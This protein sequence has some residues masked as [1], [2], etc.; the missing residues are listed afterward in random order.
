MSVLHAAHAI[1]TIRQKAAV[2]TTQGK[3][4]WDLH[5]KLDTGV[6]DPVQKNISLQEPFTTEEYNKIATYLDEALDDNHFDQTEG[7]RD[8]DLIDEY[9]R[10]LFNQLELGNVVETLRG[11]CL[12]IHVWPN[13]NY[14]SEKRSIHSMQ[15][16]QLEDLELWRMAKDGVRSV[17]VCRHVH[18]YA[19]DSMKAGGEKST[20][21]AKRRGKRT[22]DVLLVVARPHVH[23]PPQGPLK[24]FN[25]LNP[26]T[27]RSV[28]LQ[29]QEEMKSTGSSESI[30]LEVVR[31]GRL[32]ELTAHLK[33]REE[34]YKGKRPYDVVHFDMHGGV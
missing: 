2:T 29:L 31:P 32:K 11:R 19:K 17:T 5:W 3:Y 26:A 9:R 13:K 23:E 1:L 14:E 24:K 18:V 25:V 15:W 7:N 12:E 8:S 30:R 22:F 21:D 16:E 33:N 28:L 6:G 10:K 20:Q 4:C 34:L 27:I